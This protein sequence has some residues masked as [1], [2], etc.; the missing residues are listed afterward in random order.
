MN[1]TEPVNTT[2]TVEE[3]QAYQ[4][5]LARA[6]REL[7]KQRVILEQK[8]AASASSA[9]RANLSRQSKTLVTC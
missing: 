5:R 1:G 3:L 2:A 6:G 9:R 4:Y 7:E 8:V